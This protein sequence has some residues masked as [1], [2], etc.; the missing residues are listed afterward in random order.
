MAGATLTMIFYCMGQDLV[1]AGL[2]VDALGEGVI[3][4]G[5][6]LDLDA[7]TPSFGVGSSLW[8]M[9][10]TL[11]RLPPV[12]PFPVRTLG[13]IAASIF[14]ATALQIISGV[15]LTALSTPLFF[16]TSPIFATT[17]FGWLG[18]S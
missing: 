7:A 10:L 5:V 11:I 18:L 6:A 12:F 4:S 13:I 16:F 15:H 1:A 17:F 8:A 14:T 2:L 9:A 3:L